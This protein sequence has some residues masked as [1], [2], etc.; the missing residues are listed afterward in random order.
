MHR[1]GT[2]LVKAALSAAHFAGVD[3][4]LA[5]FTRGLGVIFMLHHVRPDPPR[6]FEP[7][8]ILK[9][10]PAFLESVIVEVRAAGFDVVSLDEV[11]ARLAS[12]QNTKPFA[13]FTLD[14]GYKDNREFAYP[15]FKRHD[16]P[17]AIYVPADYADGKGDLWWLVLETVIG[18]APHVSI[19]MDGSMRRFATA[20]VAEKSD[21]YDIIYWWLRRLPED[22]ARHVVAELAQSI[23]YDPS[24]LCAE[25]VM[26]WDEL[27]AL[28]ADPL[29]TIAAHTKSHMALGKLSGEDARAEIVGSIARI[30]AELGRPCRHFSYPYGDA[31]SAGRREF[32][33]AARAGLATAVTTRKGLIARRHA[34]MMTALPRLSLNGDF[35][36]LRYIKVMLSG[37]PFAVWNAVHRG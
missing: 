30:E 34:R 27:R 23:G 6:P 21:A 2:N 25:L 18:R 35:Q 22:R 5:P 37:A 31:E 36:D 14:D 32:D 26:G 29:I 15:V 12:G 19:Q 33:I 11:A 13:A 7:N 28:A 17:F 10:T 9:V 4:L 8:R 16:V 24:G 3:G 1:N 20:T